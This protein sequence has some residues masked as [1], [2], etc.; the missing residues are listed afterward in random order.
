MRVLTF[1]SL[2]L[3]AFQAGVLANTST[4]TPPSCGLLCIEQEAL[5]SACSLTDTTCI[6]TNVPLNEAIT[7]CV[8]A[9]CTIR[10][11]I[12]VER[13][14]KYTCGAPSRDRTTL[15]W[16]IGLVFGILGLVGFGLRVVSRVLVGGLTW[17]PDDWA[18]TL[19]VAC[20]IPLAV[21]S[22]PLSQAGLG[23]D[24]WNVDPDDITRILY[25]YFYDEL[26]YLA[27]LPLTKISILLCYLKIFPKR[28]MKIAIWVF[29][30]LNIGYLISFEVVSIFQCTPIQGAWRGWDGEFPTTCR[31]I[32]VQGW[33]AA[34]INVVLDFGTIILP[35]PELY[36][37]SMSRKKKVQIML[38]FSVGFF[39]SIVSIVRFKSLAA[40]ASTANITQDYVEIGVWSTIE[41][42]V[43]I[44]CGCMPA[45]RSLFGRFLPRVFGSSR[46]EKSRYAN[47]TEGSK[48]VSSNNRTVP[49]QSVV[50]KTEWVVNSQAEDGTHLCFEFR[51]DRV[52]M[53]PI[54]VNK[55]LQSFEGT[56]SPRLIASVHDQHV[57][58]AKIDGR[59]IFPAQPD[60]DELFYVYPCWHWF[61]AKSKAAR[62]WNFKPVT[63]TLKL[64][65][66]DIDRS[67]GKLTS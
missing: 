61:Q 44:I 66:C 50:V 54:L 2:V 57:K 10:E 60:A 13:Y 38:M 56:W 36:N 42:P 31:N 18:M 7:A 25:L 1:V 35:L 65:E 43:G 16:V 20:M 27:A 67:L 58:V 55:T 47:I 22:Y 30:A 51:D 34:F 59:F 41:V 28:E 63:F 5:S 19:A 49:P 33:M 11:Q 53:A 23:R 3:V 52:I 24:I 15:V 9:N 37:L 26:V 8:Q 29:I 17:G 45:M 46:K 64:R 48:G 39:V 21:L 62:R 12:A 6:C 32:N 40:Y 14:S 4:T